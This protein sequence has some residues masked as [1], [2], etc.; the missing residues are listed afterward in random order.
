MHK[1]LQD[2][3]V[4]PHDFTKALTKIPPPFISAQ[5]AHCLIVPVDSVFRV[6]LANTPEP[7]SENTEE[8]R[9]EEKRKRAELAELKNALEESISLAAQQRAL[10]AFSQE[11][12]AQCLQRK[13]QREKQQARASAHFEQ[14][15][16]SV[17]RKHLEKPKVDHPY[18]RIPGMARSRSTSLDE[19]ELHAK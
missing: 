16:S 17:K 1:H 19:S 3:A 14:G 12:K 2:A 15:G 8:E 10:E 5:P 7:S 9:M 18:D 6:E 4:S 13:A 11:K